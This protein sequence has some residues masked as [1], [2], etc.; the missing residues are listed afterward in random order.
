M[1]QQFHSDLLEIKHFMVTKLIELSQI[2]VDEQNI[3]KIVDILEQILLAER[4]CGI[5]TLN[6]PLVVLTPVS[7]TG[8]VK[9]TT[10]SG[11]SAASTLSPP[12]SSSTTGVYIYPTNLNQNFN[13]LNK[14]IQALIDLFEKH[15]SSN[16]GICF[17]RSCSRIFTI[18]TN[19]LENYYNPKSNGLLHFFFYFIGSSSVF[20][21]PGILWKIRR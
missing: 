17:T 15:F 11:A 1:Q 14:I 3:L 16:C 4:T 12:S 13:Y 7:T 5:E 8:L 19:Y 20:P 9:T 6:V 18:L 2:C 10:S 21:H